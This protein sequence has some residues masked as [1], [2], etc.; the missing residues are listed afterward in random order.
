MV[1]TQHINISKTAINIEKT[2]IP[3]GKALILG[4]EG[5]GRATIT[6]TGTEKS[7][8]VK[9]FKAGNLKSHYSD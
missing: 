1:K 5:T 8:Y 6:S 4:E 3:P 9:N 7:K 2:C